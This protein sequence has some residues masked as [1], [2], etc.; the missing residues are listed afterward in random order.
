MHPDDLN[1]IWICHECK[2]SFVFRSDVDD[3]KSKSGHLEIEKYDLT[4]GKLLA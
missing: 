3:H 2:C 4:S 1:R